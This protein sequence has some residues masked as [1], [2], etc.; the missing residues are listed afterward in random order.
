MEPA[1]PVELDAVP[2]DEHLGLGAV[3]GVNRSDL[4]VRA[5]RPSALEIVDEIGGDRRPPVGHGVFH[6]VDRRL[7]QRVAGR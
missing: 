4:H 6:A 3:P 1:T 5:L 7:P 2:D